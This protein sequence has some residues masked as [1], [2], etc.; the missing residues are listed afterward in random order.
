MNENQLIILQTACQLFS[1]FGYD[2]VGVQQIVEK[3]GLTKPTLYHYFG[4][5]QGLLEAI[6]VFNLVPF[7]DQLNEN[8]N[9]HGDIQTSLR[10]ILDSYLDFAYQNSRFFLLWMAL[11]LSP[12]Q[13]IPYQ[14]IFPFSQKHQAAFLHFFQNV[15]LQHGNMRGHE[16]VLANSFQGLVFNFATLSLQDEF[17]FNLPRKNQIIHQFMHGI[18]S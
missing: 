8:L 15:S 2:G 7:E 12:L 9:Y 3:A 6:L 14:A 17:E 5:K 11:R 18:F 16:L 4:S 13:S 1:E 10:N